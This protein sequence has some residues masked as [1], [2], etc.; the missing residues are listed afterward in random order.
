MSRRLGIIFV[1]AVVL[2]LQRFAVAQPA[3]FELE[4]V[5]LTDWGQINDLR[6]AWADDA[7]GVHHSAP[8]VNSLI[9]QFT[10]AGQGFMYVDECKIKD[11]GYATS[12]AD[13]GR[14]LHHAMLMGAFLH[15][16]E[17]RFTLKGCAYD[18]PRL[19]AVEIR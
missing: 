2:A 6:S 9:R 13:P 16:K 15:G 3:T 8:F 4:K 12:P 17:V 19:I 5:V 18:Y 14:K 7:M 1:C 10:L 11:N